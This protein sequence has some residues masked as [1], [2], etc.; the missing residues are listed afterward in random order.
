MIGDILNPQFRKKFDIVFSFGVLHHVSDIQKGLIKLYDLVADDG[1]FCHSV[2]SA[3]NN[4]F[5]EKCFTPLRMRIFRYWSSK[6][7]YIL[8]Q[9]LGILSF[10]LF[11]CI[12][13]P[14]SLNPISNAWVQKHL[15]YYDYMILTIN[16]LGLKQWI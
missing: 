4:W 15:F 6:T 2:Y 13:K 1:M 7:K 5:L 10:G 16:K 8:S 12:Y 9:I 14:F 3:E 11:W